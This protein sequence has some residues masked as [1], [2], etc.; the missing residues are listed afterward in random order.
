MKNHENIMK[1]HEGWGKGCGQ[2]R[3]P[4]TAMQCLGAKV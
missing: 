4:A 3:F 1:N 2:M